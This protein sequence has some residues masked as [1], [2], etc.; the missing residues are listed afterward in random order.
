MRRPGYKSVRIEGEIGSTEFI[1]NYHAIR[2]A[3]DAGEGKD[4]YGAGSEE[5]RVYLASLPAKRRRELIESER[6]REQQRRA[7]HEQ[8]K[9]ENRRIGAA[10][11]VAN[12][13]PAVAAAWAKGR[14]S[15]TPTL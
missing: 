5:E 14:T 1:A 2:A 11:R 4:D 7:E 15:K 3:W 8:R 6:V 9:A 13:D 10:R 12:R